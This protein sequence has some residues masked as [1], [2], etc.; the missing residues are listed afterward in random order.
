MIGRE[1]MAGVRLE[2]AYGVEGTGDIIWTPVK[3]SNWVP[4]KEWARDDSGMGDRATPLESDVTKNFAEINLPQVVYILAIGEFIKGAYGASAPVERIAPNT[5]VYDHTNTVPATNLLPSYTIYF[6]DKNVN[7]KMLGCKVNN[8]A[9]KMDLGE[10]AMADVALIGQYPIAST[11]SPVFANTSFGTRLLTH[12]SQFKYA[13][14]VAGLTG[15]S[16]S[17]FE[18]MSFTIDN[19]LE[20]CFEVGD[21]TVANNLK[22]LEI[23]PGNRTIEGEATI[24]YRDSTYLDLFEAEVKQALSFKLVDQTRVIGTDV[25][26]GI[27]LTIARASIEDWGKD[28][29]NDSVIKQQIK[30]IGHNDL[31]EGFMDKLVITNTRAAY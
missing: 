28:T 1:T 25:N 11:E 17:T 8:F 19:A 26:P 2:S 16:N 18:S 12:M 29:S 15:A 20:P 21:A 23:D 30:F 24:K 3:D 14:T 27:D 7:K 13:T 31:D 22:P 5:G 4:K 6:K 9:L 10:Y